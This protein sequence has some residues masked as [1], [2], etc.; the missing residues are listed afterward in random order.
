VISDYEKLIEEVEQQLPKDSGFI[1]GTLKKIKKSEGRMPVTH[2]P[3][4]PTVTLGR[5]YSNGLTD[6]K[7]EIRSILLKGYAEVDMSNC[8][9]TIMCHIA[10]KFGKCLPTWENYLV[11]RQLILE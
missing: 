10:N 5:M 7:R 3:L 2:K 1:I 9:P 8:G 4:T 6:M 11:N